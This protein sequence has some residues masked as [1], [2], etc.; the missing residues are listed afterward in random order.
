MVLHPNDEELMQQVKSG[1]LQA[2]APLFEKYHVRLYNFFLRLT[3]Q[4]E[5]S[6]DLVQDVFQRILK[7]RGSYKQQHSF[8][9]WMYQ[10][11][12]NS[13]NLY[14]KQ[15]RLQSAQLDIDEQEA[16]AISMVTN[17]AE[18]KAEAQLLYEAME[19]L[20][21]K[22]REIIEMARFQGMKYKEI[23]KLTD[24]SVIAV[25]VQVH[26]AIKR[27]REVYFELAK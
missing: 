24:N 10:I 26:R 14:Y 21:F 1:D 15:N 18:S 27:L 20:S 2:L 6:E 3:R 7:Y 8:Y 13:L 16:A 25:K 4:R 17:D 9:T 22:D 23:A 19:K 12:R 5:L 11:A